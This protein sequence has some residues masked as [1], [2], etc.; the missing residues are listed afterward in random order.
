[1]GSCTGGCSGNIAFQMED[2]CR[3]V[4]NGDFFLAEIHCRDAENDDRQAGE[5]KADDEA[6]GETFHGF[7]FLE[8]G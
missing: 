4:G 7:T 5:Q 3:P 1:M 2:Q 8:N 6:D